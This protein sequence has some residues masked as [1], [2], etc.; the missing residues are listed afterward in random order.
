MSSVK[1]PASVGI[2]TKHW[3]ELISCLN[4]C[5]PVIY[6]TS[7]LSIY[8]FFPSAH[9]SNNSCKPL[10]L[11]SS[12][13]YAREGAAFKA[14]QDLAQRCL[15]GFGCALGQICGSTAGHQMPNGIWISWA[16]VEKLAKN[17]SN[18]QFFS[19]WGTS[20]QASSAVPERIWLCFGSGMWFNGIWIGWAT[21]E[22]LAKN[23]SNEK[24]AKIAA[25]QT[26]YYCK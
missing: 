14:Y 18:W 22:K 7:Q 3:G 20:L 8:L 6:I 15:S 23:C 9:S 25:K 5:Y 13:F 16:S 2:M 24:L 17:C 10:I 1:L 11:Q 12:H 21:V 19:N 4:S 26:R